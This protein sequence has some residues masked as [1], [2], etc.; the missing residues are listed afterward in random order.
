M[1]P[2]ELLDAFENIDDIYIKEAKMPRRPV[3][4]IMGVI[5]AS[6]ALV[7]LLG[8]LSPLLRNSDMNS[9]NT[10]GNQQ[11]ITMS[12]PKDSI[13]AGIDANESEITMIEGSYKPEL[14]VLL[15]DIWIYYVDG[16]EIKRELVPKSGTSFS[17]R[18][19][20]WKTKNGIGE[21]VKLITGEIVDIAATET[22]SEVN[23]I[24][25]ITYTPG[26]KFVCNIVVSANLQDYFETIDS[27]KLLESLK[28]TMLYGRESGIKCEEYNLTFE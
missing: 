5:A 19:S 26:N 13:D 24:G 22:Y 16:N 27:E 9:N 12:P 21:E 15:T 8:Q 10:Q 11:E 25:I 23:G 20:L 18:F 4:K 1:K 17:T 14:G 2:D 6:I 3:W 7:L 28:K